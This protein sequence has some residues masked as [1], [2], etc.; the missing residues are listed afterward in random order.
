MEPALAPGNWIVCRAIGTRPTRG[1]IV[2]FPHPRRPDMWLVKRIVAL[3]GEEVVLDL[4]EV[5]IDGRSGIDVW[6]GDHDTF[7]EGRWRVGTGEV[8]VLSDNRR[9][10]ADDARS[11][12][13]IGT[14]GMLKVVWPRK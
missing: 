2:V 7:P 1:S 10:T 11:F 9:S 8:L 13:P 6:G 4:G 14:S 5:V 12:G 3:P